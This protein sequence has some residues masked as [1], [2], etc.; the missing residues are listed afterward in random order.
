MPRK[1]TTNIKTCK[2]Q[3]EHV[4]VPDISAPHPHPESRCLLRRPLQ[5]GNSVLLTWP[6]RF[7]P[8]S[9]RWWFRNASPPRP[10]VRSC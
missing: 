3:E 4:C 2:A 1:D 8:R 10:W 7:G 5:K 9:R 6:V